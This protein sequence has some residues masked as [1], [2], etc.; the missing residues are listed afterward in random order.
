MHLADITGLSCPIIRRLLRGQGNPPLGHALLVARALHVP[1]RELYSLVYEGSP[2]VEPD[3]SR[4]RRASHFRGGC[5]IRYAVLGLLADRSDYGYGLK[6]R[7]DQVVGAA[8]NLNMSQV[9]QI[10]QSLLHAGLVVRIEKNETDK[11][12]HH[13]YQLSEE[14]QRVL[15]QWLERP[16]KYTHP[17]R[18][19]LLLRLHV[20]GADHRPVILARVREEKE[21]YLNRLRSL[22][23]V[24][25]SS[26][27]PN[28]RSFARRPGLGGRDHPLRGA[29]Q[30]A[31][32]RTATRRMQRRAE[33]RQPAGCRNTV[34]DVYLLANLD[35]RRAAAHAAQGTQA[36]AATT[37]S[38]SEGV[39]ALSTVTPRTRRRIRPASTRRARPRRTSS[40]RACH[41]PYRMLHST[42]AVI[43]RLNSR[44][45]AA[46]VTRPVTFATSGRR[47]GET[48]RDQRPAPAAGRMS[49]QWN[50]ALTGSSIERPLAA[51]ATPSSRPTAGDD[52]KMTV[53]RAS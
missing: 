16:A 32:H 22:V 7:F 14:G 2:E 38:T 4:P 8:W 37:R 50:G 31:R 12:A 20:L 28:G 10:V 43:C 18:D 34:T 23:R 9:Y 47:N 13:R 53:C 33:G 5:L 52:R 24:Q 6:Q 3:D 36:S 30:V 41:G 17:P 29:A 49:S 39:P 45:A 46:S 21:L 11:T 42:G 44:A 19:E 15:D 48:H 27:P 25:G 40:P 51:R 1:V 35:R 26:E